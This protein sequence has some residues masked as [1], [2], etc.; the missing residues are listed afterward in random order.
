MYNFRR[1]LSDRGWRAMNLLN[2]KR[3]RE[4]RGLPGSC[5]AQRAPFYAL[6]NESLTARISEGSQCLFPP[7]L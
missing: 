1:H 7:K 3:A 6:F 4:N 2:D 5:G